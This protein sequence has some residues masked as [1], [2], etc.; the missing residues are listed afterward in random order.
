MIKTTRLDG[1]FTH[2]LLMALSLVVGDKDTLGN[3]SRSILFPV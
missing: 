3:C 2:A 1:R